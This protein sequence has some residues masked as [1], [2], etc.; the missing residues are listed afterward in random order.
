MVQLNTIKKMHYNIFEKQLN[1]ETN[2]KVE[3][4]SVI[5]NITNQK[6]NNNF[7]N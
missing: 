1:I 5:F 6:N 2:I 4:K 7:A 3:Y